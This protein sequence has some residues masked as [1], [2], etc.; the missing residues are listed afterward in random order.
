MLVH[1]LSM[2]DSRFDPL[3]G[4]PKD[5]KISICCFSAKYAASGCWSKI[6]G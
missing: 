4:R 5:Y 2:V 3:S 6:T 1:A